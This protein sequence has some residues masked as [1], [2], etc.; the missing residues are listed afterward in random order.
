MLVAESNPTLYKA[1]RAWR[2]SIVTTQG[3]VDSFSA[4]IPPEFTCPKRAEVDEVDVG[5][6]ARQRGSC[7][8]WWGA[9]FLAARCIGEAENCAEVEG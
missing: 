3:L 1:R 6:P 9:R 8:C 2:E 7:R 4:R 5:A